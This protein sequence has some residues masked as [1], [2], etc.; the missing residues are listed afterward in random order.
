MDGIPPTITV[1][2]RSDGIP[3]TIVQFTSG[4]CFGDKST[5]ATKNFAWDKVMKTYVRI[6]AQD[7]SLMSLLK[8]YAISPQY[9]MPDND[10]DELKGHC[11]ITPRCFLNHGVFSDIS[12]AL[13]KSGFKWSRERRAWI[14][15]MKRGDFRN[16]I[17]NSFKKAPQRVCHQGTDQ[18]QDAKQ[19]IKK[20]RQEQRNY[21][22]QCDYQDMKIEQE[23]NY[24]MYSLHKA[25]SDPDYQRASYTYGQHIK[26]LAA[27]GIYDYPDP[28][29]L[30][31]YR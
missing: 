31:R 21:D 22:L 14:K 5:L 29:K 30:P 3:P 26:Q 7:T 24:L 2:E 13:S 8:T 25:D 12:S 1:Y 28:P 23:R 18:T 6:D 15:K 10:A 20:V 11:L 17:M 4:H 27:Q 19:D 16:D 9:I